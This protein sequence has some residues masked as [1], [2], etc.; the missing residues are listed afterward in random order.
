MVALCQNSSDSGFRTVCCHF[1]QCRLGISHE[2]P[3]HG[4]LRAAANSFEYIFQKI[5]ESWAS[6]FNRLYKSVHL[7]R[8]DDR[9]PRSPRLDRFINPGDTGSDICFCPLAKIYEPSGKKSLSGQFKHRPA[10]R[11][12][13][14]ENLF[15]GVGFV[16]QNHEHCSHGL[17]VNSELGQL[18]RANNKVRE[19]S[20]SDSP[21]TPA[22]LTKP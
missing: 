13:L 19:R 2:S 14:L 20:P 22:K 4:F 21:A 3:N 9:L 7:F 12:E 15:T 6:L 16:L 17:P 8:K 11:A 5:A 1:F 10:D 18:V